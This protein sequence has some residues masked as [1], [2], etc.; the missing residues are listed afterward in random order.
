MSIKYIC[1]KKAGSDKNLER[2]NCS[3][4]KAQQVITAAFWQALHPPFRGRC[5]KKRDKCN[6]SGIDGL[7]LEH[8]L[9]LCEPV[10]QLN[11]LDVLLQAFLIGVVRT[12]PSVVVPPAKM[13]MM[14]MMILQ[15]LWNFSF[16]L[17]VSEEVAVVRMLDQGQGNPD[18][19]LHT[20]VAFPR[21]LWLGQPIHETN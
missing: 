1:R 2:C 12:R 14:M 11:S 17:P 5:V 10:C 13:M 20:S 16:V 19:N 3:A 18:S 21:C 15:I 4:S 9:P 6:S 8:C 7:Y